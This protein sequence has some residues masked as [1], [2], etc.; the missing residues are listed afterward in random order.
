MESMESMQ[1]YYKYYSS[2][3]KQIVKSMEYK[4]K[5]D[6]SNPKVLQD[7]YELCN[8]HIPTIYKTTMKNEKKDFLLCMSNLLASV[9][10]ERIADYFTTVYSAINF[11]YDKELS[12]EESKAIV[13]KCDDNNKSFTISLPE[14]EEPNNILY[15][16]IMHELSHFSM[17]Y[18]ACSDY[19][20]YSETLSMFFEY[21][22][23]EE[24]NKGKGYEDFINNRLSLLR[25]TFSDI[26]G[27]LYFAMNPNYLGIGCKNYSYPLASNISYPE[28]FEYVLNL[29][30]RR[31]EDKEYVDSKLGL[32]LYRK[33]SLD[34][35]A[36][37]LDF[38]TSKHEKVRK[39]IKK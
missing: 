27:D 10:D 2:Y 32:L 38:D 17:I 14:C 20:E 18:G 19:Y 28:S 7:F 30:D 37:D 3:L 16:T 36:K 13:I 22:M 9:T 15:S 1:K 4:L 29:I 34:S 11:R 35:V 25:S 5:Y 33:I 21:M 23:L 6:Y 12:L 26:S 8:I 24:C 31:K 39:L